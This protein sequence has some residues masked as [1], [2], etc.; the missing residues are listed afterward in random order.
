M[1]YKITPYQLFIMMII[2]PYGSAI[3]FFLG[4]KTKQDAWIAMFFYSLSGVCLQIIYTALHYKY[5][6]DSLVEY[7]PKIYGKFLGNILSG[8]YICYFTYIASRVLRDYEEMIFN[9]RL[10]NTPMFFVGVFLIIVITY[11]L[12]KGIE[13]IVNLANLTF[14]ILVGMP[15]VVFILAIFTEGLFT[16][17][18]LKPVLEN[19][20][21]E[22]IINGW[23][24]IAFPYGEEIVFT[25][26]YPYVFENYKVRKIAILAVVIEGIILSINVI[27]FIGVLGLE[28]A[29]V[30]VSP[31]LQTVSV[32]KIGFLERLDTLFVVTLVVGGFFKISIFMYA[33]ILGTSQIM[34]LNNTKILAIPFGIIVLFLSQIIAKNYFEH[35]KI[36]L[37]FVVKYIHIPLQ[38]FIPIFTLILLYVKQIFI[39]CKK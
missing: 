33:A 15:I 25:M 22:V 13:V 17:N 32:L 16:V 7:M 11:G 27:L 35:I 29:S 26:F 20:F 36:G 10:N 1:R 39:S 38:V 31:F 24:L 5:P 14:V 23:Q 12:Y 30:S 19:G 8:V 6:K 34:N 18:N 3:L 9:T 4:P 21:L 28:I 2:L 37:E